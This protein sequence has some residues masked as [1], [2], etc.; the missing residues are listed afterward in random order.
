MKKIEKDFLVLTSMLW[1]F[2]DYN[3]RDKIL[4]Y[5][6]EKMGELSDKYLLG[7]EDEAIK[8]I[9]ELANEYWIKVKDK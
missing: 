1:A 4:G 3:L 2:K 5:N 7:N 8:H 9:E 6:K